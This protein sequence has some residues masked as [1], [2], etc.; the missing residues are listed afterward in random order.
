MRSGDMLDSRAGVVLAHGARGSEL[1]LSKK[2]LPV[3]GKESEQYGL[4]WGKVGALM[5]SSSSFGPPGFSES[6]VSI[7]Q[8]KSEAE[9]FVRSR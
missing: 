3:Y 9:A 7:A 8:K 2:S 4:S 1:C 6:S 5:C